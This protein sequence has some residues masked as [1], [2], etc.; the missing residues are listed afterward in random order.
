VEVKDLVNDGIVWLQPVLKKYDPRRGQPSTFVY[1]AIDNFFKGYLTILSTQKRMA[2][3]VTI[4]DQEH[5]VDIAVNPGRKVEDMLDAAR[6]VTRL[7]TRASLDLIR[8]LDSHFFSRTATKVVMGSDR[9][10]RCRREFRQL[11]KEDGVTI[12]HYRMAIAMEASRR[13]DGC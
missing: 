10:N 2:Q 11:A 1:K 4:D 13:Q 3:L 8:F 6:V 5:P 12:E 9:F 7:H